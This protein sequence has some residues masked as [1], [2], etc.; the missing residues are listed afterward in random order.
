[1]TIRPGVDLFIVESEVDDSSLKVKLIVEETGRDRAVV[2]VMEMCEPKHRNKLQQ[3]SANCSHVYTLCAVLIGLY[4]HCTIIVA[5]R[6]Y[7]HY[8]SC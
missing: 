4:A 3:T 5:V 1:M 6:V 8:R 2:S 7:G